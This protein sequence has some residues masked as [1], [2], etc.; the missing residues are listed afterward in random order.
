MCVWREGLRR[1]ALVK[2]HT[3]GAQAALD[4]SLGRGE[5]RGV[6]IG[7]VMAQQERWA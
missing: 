3:G 7:A 1:G 5:M 2:G 4:G 6:R